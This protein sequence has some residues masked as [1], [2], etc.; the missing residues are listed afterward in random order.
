MYIISTARGVVNPI[1]SLG[2]GIGPACR[3]L[4]PDAGEKLPL[5]VPPGEFAPVRRN[6]LSFPP[7]LC[8]NQ[9]YMGKVGGK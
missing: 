4:T 5:G 9:T 3:D 2:G 1:A 8:Y 7:G 6:P